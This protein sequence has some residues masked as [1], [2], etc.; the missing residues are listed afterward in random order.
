M[1]VYRC[2]VGG[3]NNDSRYP[4]KIIKRSQVVNLKFHYFPKD[5]E[6]R[7]LWVKEV[8]K[9]LVD[10]S[11]SNNKVVCSSHFLYGK[12]TFA[13]PV[14]T[15]YMTMRSAERPSPNKRRK[16]CYQKQLKFDD[17]NQDCSST[18]S[19]ISDSKNKF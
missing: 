5:N 6:K 13:Q 17:S 4:G 14:P 15:L 19:T 12:P 16:I 7:Q 1:P 3:C 18:V 2:C 11:V 9:G 10:F 8:E